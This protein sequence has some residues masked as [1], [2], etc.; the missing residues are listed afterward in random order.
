MQTTFSRRFE[1]G[2]GLDELFGAPGFS[3]KVLDQIGA[4][5]KASDQA[6]ACSVLSEIAGTLGCESAVFATFLQDDPWSQSYRFLLA[7]HPAWCAE[8]QTMAWFADDPASPTAIDSMAGVGA[9]AGDSGSSCS[10][11]SSP[12][13]SLRVRSGNRGTRGR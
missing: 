3:D 11:V 1:Q 13:V 9:P 5:P 6:E 4:I 10:T 12:K 7:C 2:P 8:Y